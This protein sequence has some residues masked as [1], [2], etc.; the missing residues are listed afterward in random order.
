[1]FADIP[2]G[3]IKEES[4][5]IYAKISKLNVDFNLAYA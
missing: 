5:K 2:D 1:M 4:E 3:Y